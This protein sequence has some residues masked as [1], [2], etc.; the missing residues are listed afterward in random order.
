MMTLG[1]Q[2][3]CDRVFFRRSLMSTTSVLQEQR[4]V[5]FFLLNFLAGMPAHVAALITAPLAER[6]VRA[7]VFLLLLL[8]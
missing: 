4:F 7:R 6:A 3:C 5:G 8:H 1:L 2:W